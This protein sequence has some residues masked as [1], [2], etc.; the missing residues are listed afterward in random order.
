MRGLADEAGL[1]KRAEK[2][3]ADEAARIHTKHVAQP[4]NAFGTRHGRNGRDSSTLENDLPRNL[5]L[6]A[7]TQDDAQ[8][9]L[10]EDFE[11]LQLR[12]R[13]GPALCAVEQHGEDNAT[14]E[15]DLDGEAHSALAPK[16]AQ[17]PGSPGGGCNAHGELV[18]SGSVSAEPRPKVLAAV[19]C[20]QRCFPIS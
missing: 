17:A 9:C 13:Q 16:P 6:P 2:Q 4:R 18:V 14:V 11:A 19:N 7:H 12:V 1:V 20:G 5:L 3:A 15:M 8:G 10:V